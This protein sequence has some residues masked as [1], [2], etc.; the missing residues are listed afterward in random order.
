MLVRVKPLLLLMY[1]LP[2]A[3]GPIDS[4]SCSSTDETSGRCDG[5]TISTASTRKLPPFKSGKYKSKTSS[6][7]NI[8]DRLETPEGYRFIDLKQLSD[9]LLQAHVCDEGEIFSLKLILIKII[10]DSQEQ[11]IQGYP[12]R[13][14]TLFTTKGYV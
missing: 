13:Y 14:A 1:Q 6:S 11:N 8:K 4:P 9:A 12:I 7:T 2:V 10:K 3:S 5:E